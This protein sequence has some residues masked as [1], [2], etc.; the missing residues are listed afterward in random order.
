MPVAPVTE[1][2]LMV[3]TIDV[4]LPVGWVKTLAI[5][6]RE[7]AAQGAVTILQAAARTDS[8]GYHG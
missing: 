6:L 8:S 3:F 7:P 2:G 5:T 4:E 1:K